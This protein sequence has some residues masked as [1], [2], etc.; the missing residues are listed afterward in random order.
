MQEHFKTYV[1]TTPENRTVKI[2]LTHVVE[3]IVAFEAHQYV[4]PSYV[5]GY[6][7]QVKLDVVAPL[8]ARFEVVFTVRLCHLTVMLKVASGTRM[9]SAPLL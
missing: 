8:M 6:A 4:V 9:V 1:V 5:Y 7:V 3:E 2:P